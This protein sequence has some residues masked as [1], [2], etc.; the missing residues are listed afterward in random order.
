MVVN[1][2]DI[3]SK[4]E[5][6]LTHLNKGKTFTAKQ[7]KSSFGIAH[8]AS[9]IRDL[10]EQG[11]CVYSNPAVVNGSE[12]VKYRIGKPTRKMVALANA[13]A[14]SSVFTRTA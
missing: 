5:L 10:R 2:G 8:P 4:Q 6:L 12:V 7:I 3:M 1:Y 9:A 13:V 11:Y 14:G